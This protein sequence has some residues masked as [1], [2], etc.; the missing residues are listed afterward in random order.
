MAI[1]GKK[2]NKK[3]AK[4][5]DVP[6][7]S[8]VLQQGSSTKH[9][10]SVLLSPRI[11]EKGAYMSEQGIY[12]FNVAKNVGKKEIAQAVQELF[13]VTPRQVRVV[14]IP[15]KVARSRASNRTF[16]TASGKKAYIYL[17]KGDKIEIA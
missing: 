8:A 13:N 12:V 14:H 4:K 1:F 9:A 15:S 10:G 5:K 16:K 7:V 6:V 11:T 17:K 3:E 2:E